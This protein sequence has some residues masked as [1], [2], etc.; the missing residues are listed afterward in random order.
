MTE[1]SK[2][3]NNDIGQSAGG[4]KDEETRAKIVWAFQLG[5]KVRT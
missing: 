3:R 4:A 5:R 1:I 2:E